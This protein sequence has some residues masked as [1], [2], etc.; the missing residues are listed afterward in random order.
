[1]KIVH[2]CLNGVYT[3]GWSYQENLLSKYHARLGNSVTLIANTLMYDERG[4]RVESWDLDYVND[5]GVRILRLPEKNGKALGKLQRYPGLYAALEAEAP[6][7]LFVHSCQFLD[8]DKIVRYKNVH[9]SVRVFV[10]NHADFSNS[11]S[12]WASKN[13]LHK[14]LWRRCAKQLLPVTEKFY[15]VMPSRVDFLVQMYGLPRDKVE[16][17]VMVADDEKVTAASKPEVRREIRERY[18]VSPEDFLIVTGGKIDLAKK[19]TLLLMEAVNALRAPHVKLLV[20]GS[21]VEELKAEVERLCSDSVLYVGWVD[22]RNTDQMFAAADLVAFPG[23][24]SVFWEQVAG[25]GIPMI[26]KYWEGTT[27]VDVGGNVKFL[28]Q[29]SAQEIKDTLRE[30]LEQND[31][32]AKMKNAAELQGKKIFSYSEIAKRSIE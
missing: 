12:S 27:H 15:G 23:R 25:L 29:D 16:L 7:I 26:C 10:D 19:Q 9:D 1:M 6:D 11:A 8:A 32:Y 20:F 31:V 2:V 28:Y 13:I 4:N 18:G 22:A 30:I 24:H 17:L 3:E 5:D 14:L 21:V